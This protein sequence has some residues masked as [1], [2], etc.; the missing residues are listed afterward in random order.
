M[1]RESIERPPLPI[2]DLVASRSVWFWVALIFLV[3]FSF[4]LLLILQTEPILHRVPSGEVN[5]I[6]HSLVHNGT[7]SDAYGPGSGP[8]AHDVPIYSLVLAALIRIFGEGTRGEIAEYAL[9]IAGA[10]LAYGFLPILSELCLFGRLPGVLAGFTGALVPLNLWMFICGL[11]QPISAFLIVIM[12]TLFCK[13]ANAGFSRA[14]N[15]AV[16]IFAGMACLFNSAFLTILIACA[17]AALF[18]MRPFDRRLTRAFLSIGICVV[19]GI[20]PW[21]VRNQIVLGAPIA[22]RSNFGT[23]LDLSNRDGTSPVSVTLISSSVWNQPI[24]DVGEREKLRSMGEPAY[25]AARLSHA[26]Q[27]IR[28]KPVE[29]L[30]LTGERMFLFWFPFRSGLIR[31]VTGDLESLA[32]L[33]G[34]AVL[35]RRRRPYAWLFTGILLGYFPVFALL[36]TDPRYTY[37][38]DPVLLLLAGFYVTDFFTTRFGQSVFTVRQQAAAEASLPEAVR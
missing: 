20:T 37:P 23:E 7:Y 36:A 27:W 19:I 16:G 26:L 17:G 5:L 38:I 6:A 3:G 30:R 25:N 10:S 4:R 31:T 18:F 24:K 9:T 8:T 12:A 35:L 15:I 28:S 14:W 33:C 34:L 11:S 22:T 1:C 21:A 29:F 13:A 32:G 2:T